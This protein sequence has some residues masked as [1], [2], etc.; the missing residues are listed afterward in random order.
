MDKIGSGTS[1][2][3]QGREN[4]GGIMKRFVCL[5]L[6]VF[7]LAVL[8]PAASAQGQADSGFHSYVDISGITLEERQAIE[9]LQEK[10]IPLKLGMTPSTEAFYRRDGTMGG[11]SS[12][13]CEWLTTFFDISFFPATYEWNELLDGLASHEVDFTGDLSAST[14]RRQTYFMTDAIAIRTLK[15]MRI[16]GSR[17]LEEIRKERP[18]RYG[19]LEGADASLI[20][21]DVENNQITYLSSLDAA[22]LS[23][24]RG[25]ID[26]FFEESASEMFFDQFGDVTSYEYFPL[27]YM[28]VSLAT[29]NPEMQAIISVVQKA[30]N[31]GAYDQLVELY[32]RGQL[33]YQRDKLERLL[34]LDERNYILSHSAK[35]TSVNVVLES[36][37]YPASFYN[38][39]EQAFQGVAVDVLEQ[40]EELTG[41]SFTVY[42]KEF[43]DWPELLDALDSG[44]ASLISEMIRYGEREDR[45]LWTDFPYMVD[46]YALLSQ[47]SFAP[48]TLYEVFN[49]RVGLIESSAYTSVFH[50]WFPNHVNTTTYVNSNL[51]FD[52]LE[53]GEIDLLMATRNLLLSTNYSEKTGFISNYV[54]NSTYDSTF[55]FNRK[56]TLLRSIVTKAMTL[57][58]TDTISETWI[59][60]VFTQG[61]Q[62]KRALP[63]NVIFL[64]IIL[65]LII[66]CWSLVLHIHSLKKTARESSIQPSQLLAITDAVTES[67]AIL[68]TGD[69]NIATLIRAMEAI[70]QYIHA[71]RLILW[72]QDPTEQYTKVALWTRS[73]L[74]EREDTDDTKPLSID[75]ISGRITENI[76]SAKPLED[77]ISHHWMTVP[78]IFEQNLWGFVTLDNFP[79]MHDISRSEHDILK[80]GCVLL[81]RFSEN[82]H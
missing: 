80:A 45:Y 57:I 76:S 33:D 69:K 59:R 29:Q 79:R 24:K 38:A 82:I 78:V 67:A 2:I 9:A 48:I 42:N 46:K 13:L 4:E 60:K 30:L 54:F 44:Q 22:Y 72:K 21:G 6:S 7:M 70:G 53:K 81:A 36:D 58:D 15:Y 39:D 55:G 12:Y 3:T 1:S 49:F 28:K 20:L 71:D 5:L 32:N 35:E 51:A 52:A 31:E 26:A 8:I 62:S 37:N 17:V 50:E 73:G 65:A 25:D 11:F 34:T 16:T 43:T 40:V 75:A 61:E 47:A 19:F 23:L 14:H 27:M 74:P 66:T 41:L 63:W 77:D 64:V 56:E 18:L 68:L 10:G